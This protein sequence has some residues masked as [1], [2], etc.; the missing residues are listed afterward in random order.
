VETAPSSGDGAAA[1][2]GGAFL[3]AAQGATRGL[4]LLFVIVATRSVSESDFGRFSV[5]S[6][7]LVLGGLVADLGTSPALVRLI[8]RRPERAPDLIGGTLLASGGLGALGWAITVGIGFAAYNG[9]VGSDVA[10]MSASLPF[11]AV[12]TSLYAT[13]DGT[14][15]IPTRALVATVQPLITAGVAA[16]L[17]AATENV[18]TALWCAPIGAAATTVVGLLA[19]RR[20]G[21]LDRG[22]R[23]DL[24]LVRQVMRLALPFALF[25]GLGSL[26]ARFDLLLLGAHDGPDAAASYDLA[27]RSCESLWYLHTVVT[28]PTM[29]VLSRRLGDR[30]REGA[31]RAYDLAVRISY[32]TGTA[33]SLL[34]VV[35]SGSITDVLGGA[36]YAHASAALAI[37]GSVLWLSYVSF[38]QGTL[39][40]AGDHL[41]AGLIT[42]V[43]ITAV[44]VA[45]D[46]G[47]ILPFGTPGAAAAA[48]IGVVATVVGCAILHRR[49]LGWSTALPPLRLVLVAAV[50]LAA[51]LLLRR[52]PV[53]AGVAV[54]AV[55]GAGLA[56][57]RLLPRDEL[58]RILHALRPRAAG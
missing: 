35:L 13:L 9:T 27:L 24:S 25:S 38:V 6:G 7:L 20:A 29:V 28:V 15:R 39:I 31:R 8:S 42:V 12:N 41:R 43:S 56:V 50:A 46:V 33:V 5:A 32:L 21:L 30:D 19:L 44:V 10:I 36:D 22:A 40:L 54:A 37:S 23:P 34:V 3:T 49:T 53:A 58:S 26:S 1:L 48:A 45:V 11:F 47:L 57:T 4:L 51:G 16:V 2:R 14:G 18:R 17:I 52:A 55:Y